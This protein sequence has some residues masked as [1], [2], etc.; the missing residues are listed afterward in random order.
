MLGMILLGGFECGLAVFVAEIGIGSVAEEQ[1]DGLPADFRS[2]EACRRP[3]KLGQPS[4]LAERLSL[5]NR[6][7]SLP[8]Q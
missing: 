8:G 2:V 1:R 6:V 4:V 7:T 5:R 3:Q